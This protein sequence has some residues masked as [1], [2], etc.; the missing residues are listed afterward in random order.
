M[1]ELRRMR[2]ERSDSFTAISNE[3]LRDRTISLKAKGLMVTVMGLP[4]DWDFSV[5]G[6]IAI[7]KEGKSAVYSII[8]ELKKA[9]YVRLERVYEHG[10]IVAWEYV[11]SESR[12]PKKLLTD[13]QEVENQDI[14]N[15][16]QYKK[17]EIKETINQIQSV[18]ETLTNT[19]ADEKTA[20]SIIRKYYPDLPLSPSWIS[21]LN[22]A[23][24][25]FDVWERT[26]RDWRMNDYKPGRKMFEYYQEELTG[27][28]FAHFN[29]FDP[30]KK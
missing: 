9:G 8:N 27:D 25:D 1:A 21:K 24:R 18:S 19:P 12:E 28:P 23:V 11:F 30:F 14:E 13:F 26:V 2:R 7:V 10:R 4:P 15:R 3:I 29:A 22:S 6:I 17:Q 16:T 5:P 20:L